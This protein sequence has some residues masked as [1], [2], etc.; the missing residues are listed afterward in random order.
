LIQIDLVHF[1]SSSNGLRRLLMPFINA[2]L[3]Y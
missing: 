2:V 3:I 1:F